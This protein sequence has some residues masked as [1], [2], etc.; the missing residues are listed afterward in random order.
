MAGRKR[1]FERSFSSSENSDSSNALSS[2][3]SSSSKKPKRQI[4]VA[5]FE[6][7]QRNFDQEH[8]TLTW[9]KCERDKRDRNLV[10]LLWCSACREYEGRI[11]GM[12]NY[13]AAW[14]TG[15]GN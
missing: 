6:K 5:T 7:W 2:L 13:S 3:S 10:E 15:S 9:L 8:S 11:C 14:V 4:T 12:K 1:Y